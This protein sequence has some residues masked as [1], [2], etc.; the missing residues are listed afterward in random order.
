M[1]KITLFFAALVFAVGVNAQ[2]SFEASE[3]Y[4]LGDITGQNGWEATPIQGGGNVEGQI[5]TDMQASDGEYSLLITNLPQYGPQENP[6]IGGFYDVPVQMNPM[7]GP[8]SYTYDI[9]IDGA[10][11]NSTSE[12]LFGLVSLTA[13]A[14][15]SYVDFSF[16]GSIVA[17][18]SNPEGLGGVE[19]GQWEG[20]TW[21]TVGVT[22]EGADA[23]FF[24]NGDFVGTYGSIADSAIE[25]IRFIHDNYGGNAYLDNLNLFEGSLN[26][27]KVES[28]TFNQ[29][30]QNGQLFVSSPVE[31]NEVAIYN[32]LG[33]K[34]A[35][36]T[37]NATN[38]N[39]DLGNLN[40][41]VYVTKIVVDGSVHSFKFI[42]N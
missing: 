3:G 30:I 17:L 24:L 23:H 19:L 8:V 38:G 10:P 16:D 11:S 31:I 39:L 21:Y 18:V 7:D 4:T 9:Y 29:Y 2:I 26:V 1:K 34:V 32:M 27:D 6:I 22:M 15:Q 41:G 35:S 14:F 12:F 42:L 25:E 37:I 20:N 36:K 5:I 13:Q 28:N 33:Q 40:A